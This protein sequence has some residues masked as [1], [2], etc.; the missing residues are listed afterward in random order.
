MCEA[1]QRVVRRFATL[2]NAVHATELDDLARAAD[3]LEHP[4]FAI[5]A[6]TTLGLR[7]EHFLSALPERLTETVRAAVDVA[8]RRALRL[9]AATMV[10][11]RRRPARNL[12]HRAGCSASGAVG[13]F[14]GM[15]ALLLEL[16]VSTVI[17]LRSILDVARSQG[18]DPSS[19]ETLLHSLE[20]LALRGG[21]EGYFAVRLALARALAEAATYIAERGLAEEGAPALV[22]F[23]GKIAARFGAAVSEKLVAQTVPVIGAAAGAA[24]NLIFIDDFQQVAWAH[25]TVLRLEAIYGQ[26]TVRRA[27]EGLPR[28]AGRTH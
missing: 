20:V 5:R 4:G 19:P 9:A 1:A 7:A 11:T 26:E 25:F 18:M 12:L 28:C 16:P 6:A 3:I 17:M 21:R 15:G 22:R 27:Y 14:F 10:E 8:L 23:L 13:G 2:V 24:I